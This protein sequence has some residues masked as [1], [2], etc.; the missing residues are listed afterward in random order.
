MAETDLYPPIK[1]F[2]EAQGYAVK[3]EVGRCDVVAVRGDEAPV[4]V[5]LKAAFSL[6][7]LL[8]GIDRQA[9]SDAVY[10][11]IP[12]PAYKAGKDIHALCKRLGLGLVTVHRG[13]A[14]AELDPAPYQPRKNKRRTALLLKEFAHRHG[15][16]NCGGSTRQPLVTAYRQDALRCAR[17]LASDGAAKVADIRI[18]TQVPRAAAILQNDV[19]GWFF[20]AERGVYGLTDKGKAA[21]T[22]YGGVVAGL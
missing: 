10:L 5:E 17:L 16:P 21:L 7:L 1:R 12:A 9:M 15:D 14:Q 20:R 11:A 8:Q 2:L 19:Y 6:K 4:I 3:G 18:R 13:A 22:T